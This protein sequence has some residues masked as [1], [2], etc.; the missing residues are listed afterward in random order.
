[1]VNCRLRFSMF[2]ISV[3]FG[4]SEY[5]LAKT[6]AYMKKASEFGVDYVF[7]SAHMPEADTKMY[8]ELSETLAYAK[9]LDMKIILDISKGYLNKIDLNKYPIYSLRLDYGFT[10]D[11]IVD[12]TNNSNFRIC[13]NASTV[14]ESNLNK[15]IAKKIN[16]ENLDVCH[17]FYPKKYSGISIEKL[18]KQNKLFKKYNLQT[19]AF[20]PSHYGKRPPVYEGLPTVETHRM[21]KVFVSAQELIHNLTD[22]VLFGDAYAADS[23]LNTLAKI[24]KDVVTFPIKIAELSEIEKSILFKNHVDRRDASDYYIRSSM[25]RTKT[26][27]EQHNNIKRNKFCVTIDNVD[28]NR[29]QGELAI[30]LKDLEEDNRVNVVGE[31]IDCADLVKTIKTGVK[32]TF[33]TQ[34]E[35]N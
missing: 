32:F 2:G 10:D 11:E 35:V 17:N 9:E 28:Y 21:R 33:I 20:I 8:E 23:E 27:I 4:L 25:N 12:L 7:T 31:L 1:M 18:L 30:V 24:N 19:M 13:L 15:L 26:V 16:L 14:N 5:S 34:D 22:F 3:Y 6:K 29:Y